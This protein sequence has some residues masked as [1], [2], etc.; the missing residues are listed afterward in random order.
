[1][2]EENYWLLKFTRRAVVQ[3][4]IYNKYISKSRRNRLFLK[5]NFNECWHPK[6]LLKALCKSSDTK[7]VMKN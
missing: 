6:R 5:N 1:M 4:N 3:A 7:S 2:A